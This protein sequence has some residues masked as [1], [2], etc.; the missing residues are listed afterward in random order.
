MKVVWPALAVVAGILILS[1]WLGHASCAKPDVR[2]LSPGVVQTDK[3]ADV[4]VAVRKARASLDT[5]IKRFQHPEDGDRAFGV[6]AAFQ[7]GSEPEHIWIHLDTYTEGKF[8]GR[9]GDEPQTLP[10]KH[11]GDTVTVSKDDV[12]DWIYQS[13]GQKVG[14]YTIDAMEGKLGAAGG[15]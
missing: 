4:Y 14:G 6:Q 7:G 5:F 1:V 9:L 8:T 13:K 2:L 3:N 12:T 10:G 11:K 15:Q